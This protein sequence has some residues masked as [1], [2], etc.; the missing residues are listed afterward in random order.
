[1]LNFWLRLSSSSA[2]DLKQCHGE[3]KCFRNCRKK[4][5]FQSSKFFPETPDYF[6]FGSLM[7]FIKFEICGRKESF[8]EVNF[9]SFKR[10][11][12]S[13]VLECDREREKVSERE[14]E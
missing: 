6:N 2:N 14:R 5:S 4:L 7:Q 3:Q 8:I 9:V 13:K 11:F 1:M 12:C 10:F